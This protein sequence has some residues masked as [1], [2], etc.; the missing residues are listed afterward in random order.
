MHIFA[1]RCSMKNVLWLIGCVLMI[2]CA[3]EY[4]V[5]NPPP[6]IQPPDITGIWTGKMILNPSRNINYCWKITKDSFFVYDRAIIPQPS[7]TLKGT[8]NLNGNIFKAR[9]LW[10]NSRNI[11]TD[12]ATLSNDY[13][14]MTGIEVEVSEL[15]NSDYGIFVMSKK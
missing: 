8:W 14:K 13:K 2:S 15:G 9:S 3:K 5:E 11:F 1:E 7:P 4:S 6:I 12:S 10:S